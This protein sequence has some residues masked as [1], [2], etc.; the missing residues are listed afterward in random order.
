M[1]ARRAV[2]AT[3]SG[4][5]Q[6]YQSLHAGADDFF[7]RPIHEQTLQGIWQNIWRKRKERHMLAQLQKERTER[8]MLQ[9]TLSKMQADMTEAIETPLQL[10][11]QSLQSVIKDDGVSDET[12]YPI[13]MNSY[14]IN[15]NF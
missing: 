10:I 4:T 13:L 9:R 11:I 14:K 7:L 1:L 5:N 12:R 6:V 3:V 15:N 8:Q 2:L